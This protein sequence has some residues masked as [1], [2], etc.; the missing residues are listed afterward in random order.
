MLNEIARAFGKDSFSNVAEL[1]IEVRE[2][3]SLN[4]GF[5]K[6]CI[7]RFLGT[8][9][10]LEEGGFLVWHLSIDKEGHIS[11]HVLS[12]DGVRIALEDYKWIFDKCASVE[13]GL[14]D[15]DIPTCGDTIYIVRPREDEQKTELYYDDDFEPFGSPFDT[16]SE[17]ITDLFHLL[18]E[19]GGADFFIMGG[20][21]SAGADGRGT[22]LLRINGELPLRVQT[23]FSMAFPNAGL[24]KIAAG[25]KLPVPGELAL[26]QLSGIAAGMLHASLKCVYES[27][28]TEEAAGHQDVRDG[29]ARY[30]ETDDHTSLDDLKL[31]SK[32]RRV[33]KR[34]G[35]KSVEQLRKT[36]KEELQ[37]IQS[38]EVEDIYEI[39]R[40][41]DAY[42]KLPKTTLLKGRNYKAM[43]DEL[44][45]LED[46]KAQVRKI[47]AYA[48]MKKDLADSGEST[49][50]LVLNME[51]VG[52]P[53]TA[54]TTVA[55]IM[56]GIFKEIGL[57]S[58][59]EM[60][61]VGRA[62]LV[63]RYE[64]QTAGKVR[65]LFRE[66]KGKILFIDEAY[67]LFE[68]HGDTFGDEAINT[69]VQEMENQREDT[70]VIFAGYPHKMEAFF[71]R[72]PGLSS[73]VP[74]K[75]SF[76][77]YSAEE[78]ERITAL[79]AKRRGFSLGAEAE[80]LVTE[81]CR[82][83]GEI[84]DSGNGR[85]CRNLVDSAILSYAERVYGD[86]AISEVPRN[87]VLIRE[88]F[89]SMTIREKTREKYP[90]G[91]SIN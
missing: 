47:I 27:E 24:E 70:V 29:K 17:E 8:S 81:L 51:F 42:F 37:K 23:L 49:T 44:I 50:P 74:F 90:L 33:L 32:I 19:N 66:A 34:E 14:T 84:K 83:A 91:F 4:Y 5:A 85:F 64:G 10:S 9:A 35:I 56:A 60:L 68:S 61:E 79:E 88:D 31:P 30:E 12:S 11:S 38:L 52:N 45:G 72:N 89:S 15:R 20:K 87:R 40:A 62:D 71:S 3:P 25:V 55:R 18:S 59:D 53:G 6:A 36:S 58:C 78:M 16:S 67:S 77:D 76:N 26:T 54:K 13:G 46:V 48:R 57:L 41:V 65:A 39:R 86:E 73:R 28:G 82:K 7:K 21:P 69:I 43:L 2:D 63:A 1:K 75:I 80:G 22:I